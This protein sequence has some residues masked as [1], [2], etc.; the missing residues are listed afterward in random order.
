MEIYTHIP[1][2]LT[3]NAA[4]ARGQLGMASPEILAN[5]WRMSLEHPWH[6]AATLS[7][8]PLGVLWTDA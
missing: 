5:S 7:R 8:A 1:S 2:E 3:H 4:Q 6:E